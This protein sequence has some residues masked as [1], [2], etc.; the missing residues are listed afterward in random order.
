MSDEMSESE[1]SLDEVQLVVFA[2]ESRSKHARFT[3]ALSIPESPH[4]FHAD[5]QMDHSDEWRALAIYFAEE[6]CFW[7]WTPVH[8]DGYAMFPA[9][10]MALKNL[11][12][13]CSPF[14]RSMTCEADFLE[15]RKDPEFQAF[16][17]DCAAEVLKMFEFQLRGSTEDMNLESA[18]VWKSI[19]DAPDR[20]PNLDASQF[21]LAY[22]GL[23]A[24]LNK[25]LPTQIRLWKQVD[26]ELV[27]VARYGPSPDTLQMRTIDVLVWSVGDETHFD[28]IVAKE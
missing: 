5:L 17:R 27:C 8:F 12:F 19:H 28:L 20:A 24:V 10:W 14:F 3:R 26:R 9:V 22:L 13:C 16:V 6:P 1:A 11:N 18:R 15:S 23:G 25:V 21:N 4:F 2:A 7:R